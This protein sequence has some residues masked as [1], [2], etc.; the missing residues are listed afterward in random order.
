MK[1][2]TLALICACTLTGC[3][4][5]PD[6]LKPRPDVAETRADGMSVDVRPKARP[7]AALPAKGAR[8]VAEFDTVSAEE[9]AAATAPAAVGGRLGVT[10]ASLGSPSE[11][12]LWL[13]T[14]LV[15]SEQ[16]GRVVYA[17]SGKSVAVTLIPIEGPATGGS[18]MSLSTF[19]TLEAPL[20]GL[21]EVEVF[22]AS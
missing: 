3:A 1:T 17:V 13:K 16:P 15:T 14:P 19:Q 12:G 2:L 18:R 5:L 10:V 6:F 8:T 11:P 7:D 20:T 22:S 9:K 21:P 4:R